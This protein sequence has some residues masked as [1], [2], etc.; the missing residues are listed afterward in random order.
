MSNSLSA[1]CMWSKISL[2]LQSKWYLPSLCRFSCY[3]VRG[4]GVCYVLLFFFVFF[5]A[6]AL[7]VYKRLM[8]L[9]GNWIFFDLLFNSSK[10]CSY[11]IYLVIAVTSYLYYL[12]YSRM[13]IKYLNHTLK[14]S[15]YSIEKYIGACAKQ[16]T[17]NLTLCQNRLKLSGIW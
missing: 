4:F 2:P 6:M 3:S 11:C 12:I 13:S 7:I 14:I 8:T 5:L 9:N 16:E 10:G 15:M 17:L 1:S